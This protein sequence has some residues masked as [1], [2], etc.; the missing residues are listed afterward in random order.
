MFTLL[1]AGVERLES[2]NNYEKFSL[3]YSLR[4][5]ELSILKIAALQKKLSQNLLQYSNLPLPI[6]DLIT[7]YCYCRPHEAIISFRNISR[8]PSDRN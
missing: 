7:F 3:L 2:T 1:I 8:M 6:C 5:H 4:Q